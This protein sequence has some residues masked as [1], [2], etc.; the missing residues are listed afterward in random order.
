M[1]ATTCSKGIQSFCSHNTSFTA[2]LFFIILACS[3]LTFNSGEIHDFEIY[4]SISSCFPHSLKNFIT[5]TLVFTRSSSNF[6]Y[7]SISSF[8]FNISIILR[9]SM[10]S[11]SSGRNKSYSSPNLFSPV[12]T[13]ELSLYSASNCSLEIN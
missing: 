12:E 11:K 4:S 8:L 9:S 1:S 3:I 13:K 5:A 6:A 7:F 2:H 10:Y